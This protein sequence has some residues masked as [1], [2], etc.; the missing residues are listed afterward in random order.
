MGKPLKSE[1]L[2]GVSITPIEE[3]VDAAMAR[4]P[5]EIDLS[6]PANREKV[7]EWM[8]RICGIVVRNAAENFQRATA[9]ALDEA[10]ALAINPD[11]YRERNKR[12]TKYRADRALRQQQQASMMKTSAELA[13][14]KLGADEVKM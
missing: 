5:I 2:K 6:I 1:A 12:R 3:T 10:A 14:E 7:R 11:Y 8:I 13:F 4:L 9:S